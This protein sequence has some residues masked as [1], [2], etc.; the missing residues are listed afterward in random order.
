MKTKSLLLLFQSQYNIR[1]TESMSAAEK[2]KAIN[3]GVRRAMK[4]AEKVA[5]NRSERK[6]IGKATKGR[7]DPRL[8]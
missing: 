3:Q 6:K 5:K 1:V 2:K 8:G 7:Q 4:D